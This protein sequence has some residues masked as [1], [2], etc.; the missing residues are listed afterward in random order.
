MVTVPNQAVQPG[1]KLQPVVSVER[2]AERNDVPIAILLGELVGFQ[3]F[4]FEAKDG[5]GLRYKHELR[6]RR[7]DRREWKCVFWHSRLVD[8]RELQGQQVE[9]GVVYFKPDE[10]GRPLFK[11]GQPVTA[12]G[13]LSAAVIEQ[14]AR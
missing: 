3:A 7:P 13:R 9:F 8:I 6:L 2:S 10:Y 5:S 1:K 11:D 14:Y 4:E 12:F